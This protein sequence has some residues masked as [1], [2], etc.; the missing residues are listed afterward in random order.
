MLIFRNR[1]VRL[2]GAELQF[3]FYSCCK[4]PVSF[5]AYKNYINNLIVNL[6]KSSGIYT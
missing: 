4:T 6:Y 2:V 5:T 3:K 1:G